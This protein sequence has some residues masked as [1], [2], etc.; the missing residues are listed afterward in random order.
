MPRKQ[1]HNRSIDLRERHSA[2]GD[3]DNRAVGTQ[4]AQ[5]MRQKPGLRT[6]TIKLRCA[7]RPD[8]YRQGQK[9]GPLQM[10]SAT[11]PAPIP[12]RAR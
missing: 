8:P 11:V 10:T 1:S 3:D 12:H 2:R 9:D 7:N 6:A 5:M 4:T